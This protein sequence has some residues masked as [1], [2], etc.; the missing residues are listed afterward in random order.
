M[1]CASKDS[2]SS[3]S[4]SHPYFA[5]AHAYAR[6]LHPSI[7]PTDRPRPP[8]GCDRTHVTYGTSTGKTWFWYFAGISTKQVKFYFR[9]KGT[10]SA[11]QFSTFVASAIDMKN[12]WW[13]SSDWTTGN[14]K[15]EQ[16]VSISGGVIHWIF[17]ESH[18]EDV[19]GTAF[20]M[21]DCQTPSFSGCPKR[22]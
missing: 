20:K 13:H 18:R 10:S 21:P 6:Q 4:C 19:L 22:C 9:T 5:C 14:Y 11:K 17:E 7:H 12:G 8:T 15:Y 16:G 1:R 3:C 2:C